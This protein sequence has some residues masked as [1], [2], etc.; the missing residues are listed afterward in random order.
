MPRPAA[1]AG[2]AVTEPGHAPAAPR[3]SLQRRLDLG[4][5]LAL[6]LLLLAGSFAIWL[7]L[8]QMVEQFVVDRLRHDLDTLIAASAVVDGRLQVET[9]RLTLVYRRAYSGHYFRLDWQGQVVRSRSL[10]DAD[11]QLPAL[12]AGA[13][14]RGQRE[15]P[16]DQR[17]VV[18]AQAVADPGGPRRVAVAEDMAP[19]QAALDRVTAG[20]AAFALL[21]LAVLL[22]LQRA[23][24][25]YSLSPLR[26]LLQRLEEVERGERA[27]LPTAEVPSEVLPLV[28]RFNGLLALLAVRLERSRKGLGNLAHALKTPLAV[29]TQTADDLSAHP[30]GRQ[31]REQVAALREVVER[32]LRRARL[33]GGRG[34]GRGFELG[35]ALAALV[36]TLRRIYRDK[37]LEVDCE[38]P[39]G[40]R[41][42]GDREDFLEL[43]GVLLDNAFKWAR[44][45]VRIQAGGAGTLVIRIEDD[46]PGIAA[47]ERERLLR[48]GERL[49]ERQPGAGLGLDIARDIVAEYGG[50]LSLQPAG[51]G[52]L[53]VV[54]R[55]P[56]SG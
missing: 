37:A 48:R 13:L 4:V 12:P 17:L 6:A 14:W 40:A 50:E 38:L 29:L 30:Q 16:Q 39:E 27:E 18:L 49:D 28:E 54:L 21:S 8:R 15:G 51:L 55:L 23:L 53:A 33:A 7:A 41:F 56:G 47:S 9:D 31:L 32:E 43:M 26:R 52:G 3:R 25:R 34:E 35:A 46:G 45:R 42:A 11:F 24:V 1:P 2:H 22:G 19:L 36:D 44:G 5:G 10:W 20:I